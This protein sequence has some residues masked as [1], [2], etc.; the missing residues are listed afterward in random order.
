[1]LE[2]KHI[3][4][5]I[6]RLKEDI[7]ALLMAEQCDPESDQYCSSSDESCDIRNKICMKKDKFKKK[8]GHGEINGKSISGS[9]DDIDRLKKKLSKESCDPKKGKYCSSDDDVCDYDEKVCVRKDKTSK[10]GKIVINGKIIVGDQAALDGLKE[11]MGLKTPPRRSPSPPPPPRRS[12]S[13]PPMHY[14]EILEEKKYDDSDEEND[15]II[16]EETE[17]E[18][19]NESDEESIAGDHVDHKVEEE[20]F[21]HEEENDEEIDEDDLEGIMEIEEDDVEREHE[22]LDKLQKRLVA[23]LFPSIKGSK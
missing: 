15:R 4:S 10:I 18:E 11:S 1:M 14:E 19:Q 8:V 13:P 22:K 6:P 12:P 21:D 2:K 9:K 20:T 3:T 5:D 23:C 17:L 7:I 16:L